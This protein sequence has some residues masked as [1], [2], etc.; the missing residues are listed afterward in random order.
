MNK[1]K[2][3]GKKIL[4]MLGVL[5]VVGLLIFISAVPVV[6]QRNNIDSRVLKKLSIAETQHEIVQLLIEKGDYK[7][8]V[9][10]VKTIFD[11]KLPAQYDEA[12]F[13]EI[14]IVAKK[15]YDKGQRD[16]AYYVIDDGYKALNTT[17]YKAKTLNVKAALL[18]KDGK[19]EE[20]IEVF[21]KEVE[22]REK[23]LKN[24]FTR[25]L[26]SII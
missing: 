4:S 5:L 15:L 22:L 2:P 14:V 23:D 17:E 8:A 24:N 1:K 21:K 9:K 11:L 6:A 26:K 13:K 19:I 20:A 3:A 25:F 7:K 16:L 18:K 12:V 10:E